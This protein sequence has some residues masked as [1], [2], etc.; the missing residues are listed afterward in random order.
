MRISIILEYYAILCLCMSPL[1]LGMV[2]YLHRRTNVLDRFEAWLDKVVPPKTAPARPEPSPAKPEKKQEQA[3]PSPSSGLPTLELLIGDKY[4]CALDSKQRR[5]NLQMP[6]FFTDNDFVGSVDVSKGR[7]IFTARHC[8]KVTVRYGMSEMDPGN[9]AYL[10]KINS[11]SGEWS[12]DEVHGMII[13]KATMNDAVTQIAD[14]GMIEEN[15]AAGTADIAV[16]RGEFDRIILRHDSQG[17]VTQSI[18]RVRKGDEEDVKKKIADRFEKLDTKSDSE[19]SIWVSRTI[20]RDEDK[21]DSFVI[22]RTDNDSRLLVCFSPVWRDNCSRMEFEDN[23]HMTQKM[24][25]RMMPDLDDVEFTFTPEEP[26]KKESIFKTP[27]PKPAEETAEPEETAFQEEPVDES[28]DTEGPELE[29][30][31]P[32]PGPAEEEGQTEYEFE[33]EDADAGEEGPGEPEYAEMDPQSELDYED[34]D[35]NM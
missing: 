16:S 32:E 3:Q 9:N 18:H 25:N 2:F 8:G 29:F 27:E 22:A 19:F 11:P 21:I 31:E 6:V 30:D 15:G 7:N 24:F 23:V 10:I 33:P 17:R 35:D 14:A 5:E 13:R 28:F 4:Y 34:Y 26:V 1:S 12:A 20:N